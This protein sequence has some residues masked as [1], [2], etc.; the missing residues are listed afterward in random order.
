MR[1]RVRVELRARTDDDLDACE[2]LA[3]D[4]HHVDAYPPRFADDL[5]GFVSAPG[6]LA[7]WVAAWDGAI[8]GH[9]A[10]QPTSS[11]AVMALAGEATGRAPERLGVVARLLVAPAHRRKGLGRALL[12]VAAQAAHDRDRW[13]ILD[14]ATDFDAAIGLY[15]RSGWVR[16]GRVDVRFRD[17][18]PLAEYVY[19]GPGPGPGPRQAQP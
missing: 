1:E 18:E 3:R 13:P 7:A 8:V 6:A 15:E 12:G 9:V 5:R 14:V 10:L 16:A 11:P 19:V 17:A 2:L 4:V